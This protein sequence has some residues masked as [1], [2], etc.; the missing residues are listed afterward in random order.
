M[1]FYR[2]FG[3]GHLSKNTRY[4]RCKIKIKINSKKF[5][6]WYQK[7][8]SC[9]KK[10]VHCGNWPMI[11]PLDLPRCKKTASPPD[12]HQ[13]QLFKKSKKPPISEF[14]EKLEIFSTGGWERLLKSKNSLN[15]S[16]QILKIK[17]YSEH[18]LLPQYIWNRYHIMEKKRK[19][20]FCFSQ[21]ISKD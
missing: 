14:R 4:I 18:F 21:K 15:L 17:K 2:H 7:V 9:G 16:K 8:V 20:N 13:K 10:L 19:Y 12:H 3:V 11:F 6:V 5:S 1:P